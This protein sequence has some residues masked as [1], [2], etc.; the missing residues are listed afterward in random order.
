[1]KESLDDSAIP[2]KDSDITSFKLFIQYFYGI[3]IEITSKNVGA[4]S[5]LAQKYLVDGLQNVCAVFLAE[6]ISIDN[7]IQILESLLQYHQ[8]V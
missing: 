5:Y 8:D 3:D 4:I 1:M 7:I 6:S 2:I